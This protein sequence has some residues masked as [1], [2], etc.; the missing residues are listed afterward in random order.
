MKKDQKKIV[1]LI[2]CGL[3]VG[4][5]LGYSAMQNTLNIKGTASLNPRWNVRIKDIVEKEVNGAETVNVGRTSD[6]TASF[7]TNLNKP[8]AYALY[9]V[10]VENVGSLDAKLD[11]LAGLDIANAEA[12]QNIKFSVVNIKT[13]DKLL[14]DTEKTFTVKVE[15]DINNPNTM[16]GS[17]TLTLAINYVQADV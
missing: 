17:K 13:G 9:D 4:L 3:L 11:S 1:L 14:A 15:W 5:A 12:P 7:T 16:A 10:T 6:T 2:L 8:G